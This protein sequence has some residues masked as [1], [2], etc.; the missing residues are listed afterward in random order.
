MQDCSIFR[1]A[2]SQHLQTLRPV[3]PVTGR[4]TQPAFAFRPSLANGPQILLC[5]PVLAREGQVECGRLTLIEGESKVSLPKDIV[6]A[7]VVV[8]LYF[9]SKRLKRI[10]QSDTDVYCSCEANAA[11]NIAHIEPRFILCDGLVFSLMSGCE[12]ESQLHGYGV[13]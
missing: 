13:S 7:P 5:L 8:A 4:A 11:R 6:K 12:V 10:I 2:H 1:F 3:N 9:V